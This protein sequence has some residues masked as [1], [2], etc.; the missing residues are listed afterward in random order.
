MSRF[1]RK[2]RLSRSE[3]IGRGGY[4]EREEIARIAENG[5]E[6]RTTATVDTASRKKWEMED[7]T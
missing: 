5:G 2:A 1:E 6:R 7:T 3:R 4:L